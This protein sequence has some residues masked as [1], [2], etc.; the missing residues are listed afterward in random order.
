MVLI[1]RALEGVTGVFP[2]S[3]AAC[4][5]SWTTSRSSVTTRSRTSPARDFVDQRSPVG[6]AARR[7]PTRS[8]SPS[9]RSDRT[10]DT[11]GGAAS[12]RA[13]WPAGDRRGSVQRPHGH[14]CHEGGRRARHRSPVALGVAGFDDIFGSDSSR[15]ALTTVR[16]PLIE[17]GE[18][19]VA[20]LWRWSAP[21]SPPRR[22]GPCRP[23][24]SSAASTGPATT[25][26]D[27]SRS[28]S[29]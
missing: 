13:S 11:R 3:S 5:S 17:A 1:N 19:A 16:A 8:A 15:P 24:S 14:G 25:S 21:R 7:A 20:Q 27:R 6:S 10:A 29:R 9:S 26:P 4:G 28:R 2:T 23:S 18:R 22:T 12:V